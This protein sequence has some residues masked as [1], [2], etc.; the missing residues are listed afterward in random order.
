M[1]DDEAKDQRSCHAT[2]IPSTPTET[3][4]YALDKKGEM[5]LY[6]E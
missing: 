6:D 1:K 5:R 4:R 3:S 2:T